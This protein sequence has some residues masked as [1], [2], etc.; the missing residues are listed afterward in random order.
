MRERRPGTRLALVGHGVSSA[1][2]DGVKARLGDALL[3]PGARPL[4][5]VATWMAACDVFTLPSW[6]EGTPNVVLEALASGRP[7]V[8]TNVGGIPDVLANPRSGVVVAVK[9]ARALAEGLLAALN[10]EWPPEA[11]RACGAGSWKESAAKL[12]AVL[13][14]ARR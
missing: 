1:K 10:K 11:V 7:A 12:Y 4:A 6:N 14:S 5:E 3:A 2:V 13:E 9:D 8:G